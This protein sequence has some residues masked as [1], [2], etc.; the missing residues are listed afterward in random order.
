MIAITDKTAGPNWLN[1]FSMEP[2]STTQKKSIYFYE[3]Q[4][5]IPRTL[6]GTSSQVLIMIDMNRCMYNVYEH[7]TYLVKKAGN[8]C[9]PA[10][11]PQEGDKNLILTKLY[12]VCRL[13]RVPPLHPLS[14]LHQ[15]NLF[16][17]TQENQL[18]LKCI[19][20]FFNSN[21]F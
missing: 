6:P 4:K 14:P 3:T 15:F 10:T 2:L 21:I 1:F 20:Y 9:A 13:S 17:R 5:K 8:R 11:R 7:K 12:H 19:F 16:Y 18:K